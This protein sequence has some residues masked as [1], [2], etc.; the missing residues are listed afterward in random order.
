MKN[1]NLIY[2]FWGIVALVLLIAFDQWTKMLAVANLKGQEPFV[3]IPGVLELQ[4]LENR[5]A[6]FGIFQNQ[7]WLFVIPTVLFIVVA[8]FLFFRLPKTVR[9]MPIHMLTVLLAAGAIGNF[10]DRL[11]LRYVVDFI[12]F[13]LIHFP[14]FNV[15]D[16]FIVVSVILLALLILFYYKEDEFSGVFGKHH[17]KVEGHKEERKQD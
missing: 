7:Q 15:A 11:R 16:I 9:M 17:Q 2:G 12:S 6:A 3:L 1:K 8:V 13:V 14:V 10:L 4:Y 5:G